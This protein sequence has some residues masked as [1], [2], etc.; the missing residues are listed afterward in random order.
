MAP[1]LPPSSES[2]LDSIR[3]SCRALTARSDITIDDKAI[4]TFLHGIGAE[5]WSQH[6][7]NNHHGLRLPLRFDSAHEELNLIAVL[8]LLNF[9]SG[10]REPLHRL[11]QRGAF[12]N[13]LSLVLSAHLS[14]GDSSSSSLLSA[15]GMHNATLTQIS[16][17]AQIQTHQEK[18]HPTLGPVVK[19]GEKDDDA[20]EILE[21][22]VRVLNRTGE[23]LKKEGK[24]DLGHWVQQALLEV[25]G[26]SEQMLRKI[27]DTFP[28][29][30]DAYTVGGE[31]VCILKKALYLLNAITVRFSASGSPDHAPTFPLPTNTTRFPIFADNVIPSILMH[32]R[33]I[34]LPTS[35]TLPT[36][37]LLS[38]EEATRL[39]AAS[40]SACHRI[41]ERAQVLSGNGP[42][43][44]WMRGML[45]VDLDG[46]LWDSG[47][48]DSIGKNVV[49]I[50]E[51]GTTMY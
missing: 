34:V 26:E 6:L 1:S 15:K 36:P 13:I 4:D 28:D 30:Q 32:H 3:S 40:I 38:T 19:V 18:P 20:F 27:Y 41:V 45:E 14:A 46:Y 47:K 29:F 49:R 5:T 35:R 23:V 17:M 43:N 10:Y 8:S 2:I 39:R 25:E 48:R 44:E 7:Q 50:A 9:L 51:R 21:L 16:S 12:S 31:S 42:E 24:E 37:P 11:T 22:I 33:I